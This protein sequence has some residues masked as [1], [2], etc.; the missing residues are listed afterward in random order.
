MKIK[1]PLVLSLLLAGSS[2]AVAEEIEPGKQCDAVG[3][4]FSNYSSKKSDPDMDKATA[5]YQEGSGDCKEGRYEDGIN[6]INNAMGMV[7]DG[8]DS[9]RSGRK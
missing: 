7:H 5:L 2:L 6:K 3:D 9:G 8:G 1:L 4:A